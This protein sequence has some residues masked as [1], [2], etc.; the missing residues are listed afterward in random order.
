MIT[1]LHSQ[2]H[3]TQYL[4]ETSQLLLSV[5]V[6]AETYADLAVILLISSVY[7]QGQIF[8]FLFLIFS[9]FEKKSGFSIHNLVFLCVCAR[10]Y[11][12]H[13][14]WVC[15]PSISGIFVCSLDL[16]LPCIVNKLKDSYVPGI[17]FISMPRCSACL[18]PVNVTPL[19]VKHGRCYKGNYTMA[20]LWV[21]WSN[22]KKYYFDA[23]DLY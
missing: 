4:N 7:S 13:V 17:V 12:H 2:N 16:F 23:F 22:L 5:T 18:W 1:W 15:E 11:L 9:S 10:F 21:S 20:T 3:V 8:L 6:T 14:C 19:P